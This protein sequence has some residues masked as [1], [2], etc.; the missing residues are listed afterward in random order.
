MKTVPSEGIKHVT[1]ARLV[2]TMTVRV[3][4]VKIAMNMLMELHA[5]SVKAKISV[6][7]VVTDLP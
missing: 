7:S 1:L 4:N 3:V 5:N 6:S 2:T